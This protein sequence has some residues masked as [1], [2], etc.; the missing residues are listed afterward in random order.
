MLLLQDILQARVEM[1]LNMMNK[2][3]EKISLFKIC[4]IMAVLSYLSAFSENLLVIT[5]KTPSLQ[6]S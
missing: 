1:I 5:F 4:G 3:Y 2:L 6:V